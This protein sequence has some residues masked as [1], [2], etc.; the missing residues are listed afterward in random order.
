MTI[1]EGVT[2]VLLISK[3]LKFMKDSRNLVTSDRFMGSSFLSLLVRN[4]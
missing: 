1:E 2:A 4:E 3:S